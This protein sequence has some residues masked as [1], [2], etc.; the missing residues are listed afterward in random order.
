ML[1]KVSF[2]RITSGGNFIAAIDGLRFIAIS[3]VVL[4][5][6][7]R[8]LLE[9]N[10]NEYS[11]DFYEQSWL[12]KYLT[13]GDFGVEFF[14]VIS[15]FILGLPFA[16]TYIANGKKLSIKKFFLKRLTRLEPPYILVMVALFFANVYLVNSLSFQEGFKSLLS[17]IFYVHN[18]VYGKETYPLINAVAWSLEIEVQF[19]LLAPLLG[20]VFK[21]PK[22]STRFLIII[23]SSILFICVSKILPLPFI[24][25][26]DYWCFFAIGFLLV[27]FYIDKPSFSF[28]NSWLTTLLTS[29]LLFSVFL[30]RNGG[31]GSFQQILFI[32]L[33]LCMIFI[34]YYNVIFIGTFSLLRNRVITNIGG[35]C[36]SIYLL[37]G[38]IFSVF[39]NFI[40]QYK[41]TN[42]RMIDN[43]LY[44]ILLLIITL[45]IT[46][47]FFIFIER[48][49]MD[50]NWVQKLWYSLR[51]TKESSLSN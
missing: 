30:L 25:L 19:Y 17:S 15:G 46:S 50:K 23:S 5:H 18:F 24:S 47:I 8:F 6:L 7:N 43:I 36:Y 37:H 9:R 11:V 31:N 16:K 21:F 33:Q 28:Q 2:Q 3:S 10:N 38:V 26:I 13:Y 40:I 22:R 27:D 29:I 51:H 48:P 49:C 35:M 4:F 39:G 14:F 42:I 41:L 32:C 1:D 44:A 45:L 12:S 20:L 34:I